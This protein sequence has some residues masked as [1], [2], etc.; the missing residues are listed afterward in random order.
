M[1]YILFVLDGISDHPSEEL[2]GKTP[3]EVSKLPNLHFLAKGGRVGSVSHVPDRVE[4]SS[5]I[6]A[7][8][9]FGHNPKEYRAGLGPLEAANLEI[10]LEENEIAFNARYLLDFFAHIEENNLS[11]EMIGPLSPGVFKISGDNSF[12]HLIMP[13]RVAKE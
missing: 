1:K 5:S 8:S 7:L 2:G 9:L 13:I 6:A 4:P 3:L 11:F 12:L 10:K